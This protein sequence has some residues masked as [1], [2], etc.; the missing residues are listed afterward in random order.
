MNTLLHTLQQYNGGIRILEETKLAVACMDDVTVFLNLR[1]KNTNLE[2][3]SQTSEVDVRT[4]I[5]LGETGHIGKH[6]QRK[7]SGRDNIISIQ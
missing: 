2:R 4:S 6:I 3:I 1:D 5:A 7:I